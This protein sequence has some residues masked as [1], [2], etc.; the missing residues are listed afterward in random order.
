[1]HFFDI[2]GCI[3]FCEDEE[4]SNFCISSDGTIIVTVFL[5]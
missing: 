5:V 2:R 1:M 3:L 4:I